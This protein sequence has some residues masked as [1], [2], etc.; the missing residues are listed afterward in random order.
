MVTNKE[1]R[2]LHQIYKLWK[3]GLIK[4]NS[5]TNEEKELLKKYYGVKTAKEN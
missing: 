2:A 3:G 1:K 4:E 5:L